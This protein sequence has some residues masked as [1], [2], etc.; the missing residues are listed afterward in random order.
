MLLIPG[1][2]FFVGGLKYRE[3]MVGGNVVSTMLFPTLASIMI[4]LAPTTLQSATAGGLEEHH[5]SNSLS[6]SCTVVLLLLHAANLVFQLKTHADSFDVANATEEN[7]D[8][9]DEH[10]DAGEEHLDAG[11]EH[12]NAMENL[13]PLELNLNV[14]VA[15]LG[16]LLT[17]FLITVCARNL[18]R[19]L[20]P[21]MDD[22]GFHR[23]FVGF[24][25]LPFLGG[26][27]EQLTA[28]IVAYKDN[29]ELALCVCIGGITQIVLLV[30]P[31]LFIVGA[32]T[33]HPLTL[34]FGRWETVAV[35]CATVL[36]T[37]LVLRGTSNYLDGLL[38]L[39][40]YSI[41]V[42]SFR[43]LPEETHPSD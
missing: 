26:T 7:I 2:C 15:A 1:A 5:E 31:V 24:V 8:A 22:S 10:L 3:Q 12:P 33:D 42:I 14:R 40:L 37:A 38:C 9:G 21:I 25:L 13:D 39:G 17:L 41:I 18:V 30:M 36:L 27:A 23:T 20:P 43:I 16:M 11:E 29:T 32:I 4:L 19:S 35:L 6:L 28:M 34:Y